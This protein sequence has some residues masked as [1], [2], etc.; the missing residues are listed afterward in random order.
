M[1]RRYIYDKVS[2]EM[3]EVSFD[4]TGEPRQS[5]TDAVLWNDRSYQD[6]NDPR[7]KSRT[8]HRAYMKEKGV[9]VV[10]DYTNEWRNAEKQRLEAKK[11]ID[12]TRKQD[13][14]RAISQL[15]SR[16]K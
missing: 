3:V 2:G 8:Q 5:N 9:T 7:F 13:I 4:Y 12:P 11:G 10:S 6:M 1:R 14:E 16:R 15:N